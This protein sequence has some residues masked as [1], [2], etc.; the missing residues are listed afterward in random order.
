MVHAMLFQLLV[1]AVVLLLVLAA[2]AAFV[3]AVVGL[4][5]RVSGA[6]NVNWGKYGG[7][8]GQMIF[9]NAM[10]TAE[11]GNGLAPFHH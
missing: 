2:A 1:V 10:A 11:W 9:S 3:A 6:T 5:G 8:L 4:G 7:S